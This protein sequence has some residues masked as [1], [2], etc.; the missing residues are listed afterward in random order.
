VAPIPP[1]RRSKR[2]RRRELRAA[3]LPLRFAAGLLNTLSALGVLGLL[4]G[5]GLLALKRLGGRSEPDDAERPGPLR[6]VLIDDA[7]QMPS[8]RPAASHPALELMQSRSGRLGLQLLTLLV[9]V[10]PRKRRSPGYRVLGLRLLDAHS[11]GEPSRRQQLVRALAGRLWLALLQWLL[12]YRAAIATPEQQ[13]LREQVARAQREH[14]GD[15]EALQ[16]ALMGIYR[17]NPGVRVRAF[18]PRSLAHIALGCAIHIPLPWSARKQSL[19]Q[20]LSG[21]IVV[22]DRAGAVYAP[23][24]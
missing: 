17:D 22:V 12:P 4:L 11:G 19:L 1:L 14:A 13:E 24:R 10:R 16:H 15:R 3:S 2:A 7:E 18:P 9:A 8:G 5:A 20:W 6:R 23:H 21:T